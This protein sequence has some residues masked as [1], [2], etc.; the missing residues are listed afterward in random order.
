MTAVGSD[1][2][3]VYDDLEAEER[4]RV[5]DRG[6]RPPLSGDDDFTQPPMSYRYGDIT[7]PFIAADEPLGVQDRHFAECIATRAAP[8]T[9][10]ASGLAVVEVL[11]CAQMSLELG[12]PVLLE[13][14][15]ADSRVR[16]AND[17]LPVVGLRPW[18]REHP[19]TPWREPGSRERQQAQTAGAGV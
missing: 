17:S 14:L 7:A 6:V 9:D 8:N 3:A 13:E 15:A 1:R 19:A 11:E 16:A 18:L 4:I 12:R 10:G 2:M 5:L